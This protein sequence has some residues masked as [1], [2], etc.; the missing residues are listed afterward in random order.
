MT[1]VVVVLMGAGILL[2]V[3]AIECQPIVS[4]FQS[5]ISGKP[6]DWNGGNC[7]QGWTSGTGGDILGPGIHEPNSDGSCPSGTHKIT[8]SGG[9]IVCQDNVKTTSV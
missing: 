2:V 7:N 4:T 1:I 3:S 5:I 9:K 8:V 6:I